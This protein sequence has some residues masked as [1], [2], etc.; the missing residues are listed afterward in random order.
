VKRSVE[1]FLAIV[2]FSFGLLF[3][4]S[5]LEIPYLKNLAGLLFE[6]VFK[7]KVFPEDLRQK[8]NDG[9]LKILIVA[10][11]DKETIG[12]EFQGL[13]EEELTSQLGQELYN[14]FKKDRKFKAFSIR[15]KNG[16]YKNWFLNYLNKDRES[17]K[18]FRNYL[19]RVT[20][21][22]FESGLIK[23]RAQVEH[24]PAADNVSLKLYAINKWANE[25]DID[26]VLHL[27]FND[28]PT[29]SRLQKGEYSGFAIYA[30]EA[31]LPN[32]EASRDLA[33]FLKKELSKYVAQSD[34]PGEA[35]GVVEDQEL[36]A[37]GSNASRKS[38]SLLVEYGY[39]YEPQF[40]YKSLRKEVFKE[41]AY[42]TY[43][44]I[45]KYFE[46]SF[47]SDTTFLPYRWTSFLKKG[48][49]YSV[50]VLH[51]Q[52][53]L[54][55]EGLYPPEGKNLS[56]CPIN[57]NFLDCTFQA[58]IAFQEKYRSKI[59]DPFGFT[60]G[61]GFVGARTLDALNKLAY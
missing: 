45:K 11:H 9:Q 34:F 10:G 40:R 60:R 36:I 12:A 59:L 14:Y 4:S 39:I 7:Q 28:D 48:T 25:K 33:K 56:V 53:A 18:I 47:V 8:Y 19:R 50:D 51:L 52:A 37:V 32:S 13:K 24:N 57:G 15:D 43:S 30:P 58:V 44:A 1:Y 35:A 23:E 26:I 29:R 16:D 21:F 5:Y 41:L 49:R 31:Q 22:A 61:T 38:V 46:P 6:N 17:I 54:L 2:L 27:H 20:D 55:K 3:F 42:Q